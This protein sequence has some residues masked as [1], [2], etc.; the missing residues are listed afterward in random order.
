MRAS[1]GLGC[2]EILLPSLSLRLGWMKGFVFGFDATRVHAKHHKNQTSRLWVSAQRI[3][4]VCPPPSDRHL[5]YFEIFRYSYGWFSIP[6]ARASLFYDCQSIRRT[7]FECGEWA[8]VVDCG[9]QFSTPTNTPYKELKQ[10][11][12]RR[13]F[14]REKREGVGCG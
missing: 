3:R 14:V 10:F 5:F 1:G 9:E 4:F 7:I 6:F 2:T 13:R 11:L 8:Q 12:Q